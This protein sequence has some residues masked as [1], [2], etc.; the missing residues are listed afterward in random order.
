MNMT[1]V[2]ER[3]PRDG[4]GKWTAF[5]GAVTLSNAT[6]LLTKAV[7]WCIARQK[8][9]TAS[10]V[11]HVEETV[12]L[13]Q[14]RFAAVVRVENARYLIGGGANEVVLLAALGQ[15]AITETDGAN[16]QPAGAETSAA[17]PQ[18]TPA[19]HEV[20]EKA[21]TRKKPQ[22]VKPTAGRSKGG[23]KQCA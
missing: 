14:K 23:T 2:M 6:G 20:L 10:R 21:T 17:T 16:S 22:S 8:A 3:E 15:P 5:F 13:G 9:R 1:A 7:R 19:F 12:S 11:L 4:K 18:D